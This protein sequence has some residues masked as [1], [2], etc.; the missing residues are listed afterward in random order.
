MNVQTGYQEQVQSQFNASGL[1][2]E[3]YVETEDYKT[4][5]NKASK[6]IG[7][8][9]DV[10][11]YYDDPDLRTSGKKIIE[12]TPIIGSGKKFI[13]EAR[14]LS[15]E[16]TKIVGG[17][18]TGLGIGGVDNKSFRSSLGSTTLAGGLLAADV[19][20]VGS[21]AKFGMNAGKIS[22]EKNLA[23]QLS[24]KSEILAGSPVKFKGVTD[25]QKDQ[26]KTYQRPGSNT[27][28]D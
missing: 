22:L 20:V 14:G 25:E 8:I 10:P 15:L 28:Y 2:P 13:E 16:Q 4:L 7:E 12:S 26:S 18:M 17:E 21:A 27:F 3:E 9:K 1:T 23:K 6:D 24:I 19:A 5:T 11:G